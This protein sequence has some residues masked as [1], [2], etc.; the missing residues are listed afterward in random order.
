MPILFC[1][2]YCVKKALTYTRV[3]DTMFYGNNFYEG[4]L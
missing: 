1:L 3:R 2:R 4:Q